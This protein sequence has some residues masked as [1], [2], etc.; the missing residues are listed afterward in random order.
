MEST[1]IIADG[2]RSIP[3][4]RVLGGAEAM[5]VCFGGADTEGGKGTGTV[6]GTVNIYSVGDLMSKKGWSLNPLQSPACMHICVTVRHVGRER[7]FLD[8]L[9]AA[10]EE[11]QANPGK[12]AG[13]AAIY[14]M[15]S[16]QS[17]VMSE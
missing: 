8:D 4:L 17:R 6:T 5:I 3:G 12:A 15:V 1:R 16:E 14:G 9:K 2:V 11:V 13:N 7:A 10:V